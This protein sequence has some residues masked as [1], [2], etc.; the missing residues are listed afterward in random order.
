ME[1]ERTPVISIRTGEAVKSVK[2]LKQQITDLKDRIVELRNAEQDCSKETLELQAAQRELNAV[3]G[4]TKSS[5]DAV[6]GSY[7][8]LLQELKQARDEWKQIPQ[9]VDGQLNP[10]Y[11]E[12]TNRV[13]QLTEQ[14]GQM[15]QSTG[16]WHRNV[17]NYQSAL[18]GLAGSAGKLSN[19]LSSIAG[20]FGIA[21]NAGSPFS[22]AM[23]RLNQVIKV[24]QG[25]S[26]VLGLAKNMGTLTSNTKKDTTATVTNTVAK[27]A[28]TTATFTLKGAIDALK[29][30]LTALLGPVGLISTA[31]SALIAFLP[32][33]IELFRKTG[34]EAEEM[35]AKIANAYSTSDIKGYFDEEEHRRVLEI[36]LM[37]KSGEST[38]KIRQKER[39]LADFRARWWG[40]EAIRLQNQKA[41]LEQVLDTLDE[42]DDQYKEIDSTVKS[43]ASDINTATANA[44]KFAQEWEDMPDV[45][46]AED[47]GKSRTEA[48]KAAE[49][50][51]QEAEKAR[52]EAEKLQAEADKFLLE[53]VE[54]QYKGAEKIQN[55]YQK[56]Y[57]KVEKYYADGQYTR[58]QYDQVMA[59]L[60]KQENDELRVWYKERFDIEQKGWNDSSKVLRRQEDEYNSVYKGLIKTLRG[61]VEAEMQVYDEEKELKKQRL[62]QDLAMAKEHLSAIVTEQ[63]RERLETF[64][65]LT[66]TREQIIALYTEMLSDEEAFSEKF[67]EPF[68]TAL[69]T[70]GPLALQYNT[71]TADALAQHVDFLMKAYEKAVE[72]GDVDGAKLIRDKLLGDPPIAE[73]EELT[74]A[75]EAFME[76]FA[77]ALKEAERKKK[78][79]YQI[80]K[81]TSDFLEA[82][83]EA[84]AKLLDN[85]ADAW[86]AL[87]QLQVKNGKMGEE[88]AKKSF[89]TMKSLQYASAIIQTA[90]AVTKALATAPNYVIGAIQA[91][92]ALATGTAQIAK[93]ASTE[94][95]G[96][97]SDSG[98]GAP[99]VIQESAYVP[100]VGLNS[101]DYSDAI[102]GANIKCYVLEQD[103]T[104]AQKKQQVRV[105]EAT[106]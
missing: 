90:G 84:T 12:A 20:T 74:R 27:G 31:V 29:V 101:L 76:R 21:T 85:T 53:R 99:A 72:D 51:K 75:C 37:K 30:S 22:K 45:W 25:S 34:E 26:G 54:S 86:D 15:E 106:W 49:K 66:Q 13:R 71:E 93:I 55:A 57:A 56:L 4:L 68:I 91:A 64:N 88:Q 43:L 11:T 16:D 69:K 96:S 32:D 65:G 80:M 58:E 82:Y 6:A 40:Q 67:P 19:G 73:D 50:A 9:F 104:E 2:E 10:A 100:T 42:E 102:A 98:T 28:E 33:L 48:Q 17:G 44:Q 89:K 95:N 39:E 83:G 97:T 8:A 3:N 38:D 105:E 79:F 94:F 14:I 92:A 77:K 35:G 61:T 1:L 103:I 23:E 78:P 41:S 7:N 87:L 70:M 81:G 62:E 52:Q 59:I 24:L 47:T 63:D 18:D 5:T 36:E 46:K 60:H